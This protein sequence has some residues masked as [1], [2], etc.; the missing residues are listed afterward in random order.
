MDETKDRKF[1]L[2]KAMAI[3]VVLV[4]GIYGSQHP[5]SFTAVIAKIL[6]APIP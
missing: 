5:G 6:L 4:L 1:S 3:G 2:L